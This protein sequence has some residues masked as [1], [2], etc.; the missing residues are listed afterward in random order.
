M[1]LDVETVRLWHIQLL[2]RL[3]HRPGLQILVEPALGRPVPPGI[4]RLLR[5]EQAL[6]GLSGTGLLSPVPRA[7]LDAFEQQG[8][9]TSDLILDLC[10][11]SDDTRGRVWRLLYDGAPGEAGLLNA[12]LRTGSPVAEI[13]EG[14]AVVAAGRLGTERQGVLL[15][16]CEDALARTITLIEGA[17]AGATLRLPEWDRAGS[18]ETPRLSNPDLAWI[19]ARSLSWRAIRR[20]HRVL[21]QAPHWRVGWRRV[22]GPDLLDLRRHPE[23]G[24]RDLPDDRLRFYADPF[25]I[26]RN[27][28]LTLFVEEYPHATGKGIISAVAFGP[29]GPLGVPEP[30]L[31]L[32]YHL[33]YPFVFEQDGEVWMVPESCAAGTIDL[34]RATRFPG[35]WVK[36]RTLVWGVTASDATLHEVAG[37]WWLFATVKDGGSYS[38]ALHLWSA[39]DF[40]GP[41]TPHAGNPVLIDSASA[42]PAGR[43]VER[44]GVLY[45]PVQDCRAS[46]GAAL[47]L[48]RVTRLDDQGFDQ[49]VETV[50]TAGP[51]W[52]GRRLHTLNSAG[53]FEF[54]DGS[55][56]ARRP[57]WPR[58][59]LVTSG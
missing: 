22:V 9:A 29:D 39:P 16:T 32:P 40:G 19:A 7:R 28:Q 25:P 30:V 21:Y 35:G 20:L 41:F 44:A 18:G 55:G 1:R 26:V 34:F 10:G 42:R 17:I 58:R 47:G 46:Y 24:W 54:I 33:S 11:G 50:L 48:A 8:A 49:S 31:E 51:K 57:L 56:R 38:D 59:S 15:A 45:R 23:E 36:D 14:E 3:S 2:E 6:H 53:G 4:G 5:L 52:P 43:M 12:I 37:R 27:G 13:R